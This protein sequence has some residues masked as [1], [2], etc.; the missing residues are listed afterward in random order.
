M[1]RALRV[2]A[3]RIRVIQILHQSETRLLEQKDDWLDTLI[4]DTVFGGCVLGY[5][6]EGVNAEN[7]PLTR[8]AH[9]L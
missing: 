8:H 5:V 2:A 4:L 1:E 7:S 6:Y 9:A 3:N